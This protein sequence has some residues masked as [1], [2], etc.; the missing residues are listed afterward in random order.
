[1]WA[2]FGFSGNDRLYLIFA[3]PCAQCPKTDKAFLPSAFDGSVLTSFD[4]IALLFQL[5]KKGFKVFGL[6]VQ[7]DV[8]DYG[9]QLIPIA[10]SGGIKG[11]LLPLPVR[12]DFN[13]GQLMLQTN[14]IAQ[15]LHRKPR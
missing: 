1:M 7:Q 14:Q 15:S 13:D 4:L 9:T 2:M 8:V 5:L 6:L 10:F 3:V 11:A 12:L